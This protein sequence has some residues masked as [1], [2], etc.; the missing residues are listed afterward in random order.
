MNDLN[1][2]FMLSL[3]CGVLFSVALSI[4]TWQLSRQ[5]ADTLWWMFL[6]FVLGL[7]SVGP[8]LMFAYVGL[9]S[10]FSELF[11]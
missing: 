10:I 3:G 11:P 6:G 2:F 4:N 1:V 5:L 7:A 9:R 8:I